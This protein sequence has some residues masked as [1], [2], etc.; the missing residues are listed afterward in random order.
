MVNSLDL[1]ATTIGSHTENRSAE[2][3][4]LCQRSVVGGRLVYAAGF[5][6]AVGYI[7]RPR[8]QVVGIFLPSSCRLM[9]K[10]LSSRNRIRSRKGG[11]THL[12][13][14]HFKICLERTAFQAKLLVFKQA[15]DKVLH[16]ID[17][18]REFDRT[19]GA[20]KTKPPRSL[21]DPIPLG[22]K[23]LKVNNLYC[24]P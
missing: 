2:P 18:K 14:T 15:H 10:G 5:G 9:H 4:R 16:I 1:G 11:G 17:I 8:V 22:L 21:V 19:W 20:A 13:P 3:Q 6:S 24:L 7:L 23:A 12:Y